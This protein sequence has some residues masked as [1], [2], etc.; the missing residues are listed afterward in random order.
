MRRD[1]LAWL[2]SMANDMRA[3]NDDEKLDDLPI[4]VPEDTG[5]CIIANAFNYG[6]EVNPADDVE[7]SYIQF[8]TETD[9]ETYCQVTGLDFGNIRPETIGSCTSWKVPLTPELNKVA[10][11]F[12]EGEYDEYSWFE[13]PE[14][15]EQYK[16]AA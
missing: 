10:L 9:A 1:D 16:Y 3:A 7:K 2:L 8:W 6:C 12:D 4:S 5:S 11:A 13:T 15:K 14:Y